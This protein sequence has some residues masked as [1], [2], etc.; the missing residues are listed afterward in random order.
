V[1][2]ASANTFTRAF[3]NTEHITPSQYRESSQGNGE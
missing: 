3:K 1:G 2:Y